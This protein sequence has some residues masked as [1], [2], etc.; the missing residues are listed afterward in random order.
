[1]AKKPAI[2]EAA[3]RELVKES[4]KAGPKKDPGRTRSLTIKLDGEQYHRFN[5]ARFE[6]EMT[7]QAIFV[8]ALEAWLL[9]KHM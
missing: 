4:L 3:V 6:L 1:M 5:R 8:E 7:G 2:K 9:K